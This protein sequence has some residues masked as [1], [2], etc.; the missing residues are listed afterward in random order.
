[1]TNDAIEEGNPSNTSVRSVI[2]K[3]SSQ[4]SFQHRLDDYQ[5]IMD[6]DY[7][8]R[9]I[10]EA[11]SSSRQTKQR[12]SFDDTTN[13]IATSLGQYA[14][15]SSALA[16]MAKETTPVTVS[17]PA[18]AKAVQS[19]VADEKSNSGNGSSGSK[20]VESP[21]AS[22][23]FHVARPHH[24]PKMASLSGNLDKIRMNMGEEVSFVYVY[25]VNHRIPNNECMFTCD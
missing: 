10:A 15:S 5:S 9:V 24:L 7:D 19:S 21:G 3:S 25:N 1:M 12:K 8:E 13:T 18:S 11:K 6:D 16:D 17:S 20:G 22:S 4:H 2:S 14:K 23:R